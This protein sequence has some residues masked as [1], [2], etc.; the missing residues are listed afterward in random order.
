MK[1]MRIDWKKIKHRMIERGIRSQA[2]LTRD[3]GLHPNS[4]KQK[5]AFLSTT[6]DRLADYLDCDPRELITLEDAPGQE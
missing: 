4:F 3:A 2:Q 6:L 5:G 1:V